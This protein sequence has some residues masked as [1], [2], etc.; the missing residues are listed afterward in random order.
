MTLPN[1]PIV[2]VHRSDGSG[3]TNN[4]TKY[5]VAAGGADWTLGTGD[6]VAWPADHPG[7][8]RATPAWPS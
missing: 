8:R 3:T 1:K 2:V 5:L 7:R 4:F 6:T